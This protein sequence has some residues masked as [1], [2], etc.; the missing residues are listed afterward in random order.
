MKH[1]M[2]CKLNGNQEIIDQ[3]LEDHFYR[4]FEIH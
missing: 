1:Q 3:F 4:L 2:Y